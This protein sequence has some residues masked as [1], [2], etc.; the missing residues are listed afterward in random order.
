VTTQK[1][2]CPYC[3]S[4]FAVS[5]AQLAIR[6]GYTRCGK[7]F[8]VFKADDY[9]ITANGAVPSIDSKSPDSPTLN[10]SHIVDLHKISPVKNKGFDTALDSFLEKTSDD[11]QQS[12]EIITEKT[13]IDY[14]QI[15][16]EK[17]SLSV[18]PNAHPAPTH[19][20][21]ESLS[22]FV[23][24][25]ERI[26]E[27]IHYL[28]QEFNE[29]WINETTPETVDSKNELS[30]VGAVNKSSSESQPTI[31]APT[32]TNEKNSDNDNP[33]DVDDDL[34]GYLNQNNVAATSAIKVKTT[35]VL[36]GMNDFHANQRSKKKEKQLPMHFQ[37]PKRNIALDK[38]KE[39][40]PLFSVNFF[41]ILGWSVVSLL[42]VAL[43]VAQYIFF[44]FDQLAANPRY[45]PAMHRA[46]LQFGCDVPLIDISKIKISKAIARHYP[47]DP[48]AATLFTATMTNTAA[49][50]QPYPTIHLLVLKDKQVLSGR[51]IRPSEY[52]KSGYNSQARIVPKSPIQIEFVLKIAREQIPVFALD[53]SR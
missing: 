3:S 36:P 45:Q 16:K 44:N 39:R 10:R 9:L 27:S 41:H 48:T 17:I 12:A 8:Q 19:K 32:I 22:L 47:A 13:T 34:M 18:I 51:V 35:R 24:V 25:E 7:C 5:N 49:E 6:D 53:P 29:Q 30:S 50:S 37:A 31:M 26:P 28:G 46:C 33:Q 1:T 20:T 38:L 52:L 4:V 2:R 23:P 21:P 40:K 11:S 14:D 15:K 42:M 43:L